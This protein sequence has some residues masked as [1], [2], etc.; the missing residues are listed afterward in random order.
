MAQAIKNKCIGKNCID[1]EKIIL[2]LNS[3]PVA[4]EIQRIPEPSEGKKFNRKLRSF[5]SKNDAKYNP[6][7]KDIN[8]VKQNLVYK[9]Y[10]IN[11]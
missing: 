5:L 3:E 9:T 6:E 4:Q 10:L 1:I 8:Q 7:L 11:Y 2:E